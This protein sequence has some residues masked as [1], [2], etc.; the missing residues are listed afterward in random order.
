MCGVARHTCART[1]KSKP[2]LPVLLLR[3]QNRQYPYPSC[4]ACTTRPKPRAR[5]QF[6]RPRPHVGCRPAHKDDP[7]GHTRTGRA[8]PAPAR[9]ARSSPAAP[10]PRTTTRTPHPQPRACMASGHARP[11][12]ALPQRLGPAQRRRQRVHDVR[13]GLSRL[14]GAASCGGGAGRAA[15]AVTG[16]RRHGHAHGGTWGSVACPWWWW[17]VARGGHVRGS[18]CHNHACMG[19][20]TNDPTRRPLRPRYPPVWG[21]VGAASASPCLFKL[22]PYPQ[23]SDLEGLG[24]NGWGPNCGGS[25]LCPS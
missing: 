2:N 21:E 3:V 6:E 13:A 4:I 20:D 8:C 15:A 17:C 16:G 19:D 24:A 11:H 10:A 25:T 7:Q 14:H 22:D 23:R 9:P 18:T 1:T 12:P 5:V